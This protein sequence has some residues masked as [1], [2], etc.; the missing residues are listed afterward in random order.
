MSL[1]EALTPANDFVVHQLAF[2]KQAFISSPV[3]EFVG[4]L[5]TTADKYAIKI[6]PLE[7]LADTV[8]AVSKD[9]ARALRSTSLRFF[10]CLKLTTGMS[11]LLLC[12]MRV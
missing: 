9:S 10:M 1:G 4:L 11:T 12:R 8:A 2:A 6:A 3:G 7:N 5:T